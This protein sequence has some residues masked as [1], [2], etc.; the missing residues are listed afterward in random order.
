MSRS[1]KPA[2]LLRRVLQRKHSPLLISK[3][4]GDL[5]T[6]RAARTARNKCP[7]RAG[8]CRPSTCSGSGLRHL[9]QGVD[10]A[11]QIATPMTVATKFR[12]ETVRPPATSMENSINS[13]SPPMICCGR[14]SA[15]W[16]GVKRRDS[17]T[18]ISDPYPGQGCGVSLRVGS[19]ISG[20]NCSVVRHHSAREQRTS[21]QRVSEDDDA[22]R[23]TT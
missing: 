12:A 8:E 14:W 9:A 16:N 22:D 3:Y 17:I 5:A 11:K 13:R 19:H 21:Q 4:A 1:G 7:C 20:R 2:A 18:S 15:R 6:D 23:R 10:A